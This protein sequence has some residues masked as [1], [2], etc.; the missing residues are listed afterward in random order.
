[1]GGALLDVL[2]QEAS[3]CLPVLTIS[4]VTPNSGF[5]VVWDHS[6]LSHR[7][8]TDAWSIRFRLNYSTDIKLWIFSYFHFSWDN[9]LKIISRKGKVAECIQWI[10]FITSVFLQN[11]ISSKS[12]FFG[13]GSIKQRKFVTTLL[14]IT[15]LL[16]F[17]LTTL[18]WPTRNWKTTTRWALSMSDAVAV[19]LSVVVWQ[20]TPVGEYSNGDMF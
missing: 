14:A 17:E 1:M 12:G 9:L 16:D 5:G 8:H 11:F 7:R 13:G 4:K 6:F 2:A 15:Q 18:P 10:I 3:C 19:Y 20:L